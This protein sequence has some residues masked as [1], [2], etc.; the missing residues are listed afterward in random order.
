MSLNVNWVGSLTTQKLLQVTLKH[1][2]LFDLYISSEMYSKH[3][4]TTKPNKTGVRWTIFGGGLVLFG[5][6]LV[7]LGCVCAMG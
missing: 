2:S 6:G 7:L 4:R 5:G 3:K 1:S